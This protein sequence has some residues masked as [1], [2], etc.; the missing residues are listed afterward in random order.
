MT[1]LPL[2]IGRMRNWVLRHANDNTAADR[3]RMLLTSERLLH[4]DSSDSDQL[5][6]ERATAREL[7]GDID[8]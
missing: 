1:D 7:A 3:A 2:G 8:C 6:F 5:L 4:S